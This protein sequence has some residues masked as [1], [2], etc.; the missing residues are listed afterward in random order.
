MAKQRPLFLR[1]QIVPVLKARRM[2]EVEGEESALSEVAGR[3]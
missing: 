1:A 3:R 2:R